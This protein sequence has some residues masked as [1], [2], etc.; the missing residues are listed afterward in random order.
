[1]ARLEDEAAQNT[2]ALGPLIGLTRED[3]FVPA[4]PFRRKHRA[5]ARVP[6]CPRHG[7]G[8]AAGGLGVADHEARCRHQRPGGTVRAEPRQRIAGIGRVE[9]CDLPQQVK[10]RRH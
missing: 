9:G 5:A 6:R 1:M 4:H 2:S 10:G 7:E 8:D 3:I